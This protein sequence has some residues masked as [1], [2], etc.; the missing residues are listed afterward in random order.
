M[1]ST[2]RIKVPRTEEAEAALE[3][4]LRKRLG[5]LDRSAMVAALTILDILAHRNHRRATQLI[6]A[7]SM[8]V[9]FAP[10]RRRRSR[11]RMP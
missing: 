8:L 7:V 11:G 1:K 5:R 4:R 2:R 9:T 10:R 6:E 3:Q